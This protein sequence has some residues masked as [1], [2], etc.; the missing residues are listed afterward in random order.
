MPRFL[1]QALPLFCGAA[2]LAIADARLGRRTRAAGLAVAVAVTGL[3]AARG[4]LDI[5][6]DRPA[7]AGVAIGLVDSA[8]YRLDRLKSFAGATEWANAH[9]P[10]RARVVLFGNLRVHP[11]DRRAVWRVEWEPF[12]LLDLAAASRG[13]RDLDRKV[14]QLGITHLLYDRITAVNRGAQ[15]DFL[16]PADRT[17][18]VWAAWWR[19]RAV[20]VHES[21]AI[22]LWHGAFFIYALG[23]S[24]RAPD[25]AG[26]TLV[27]PG[28]EGWLFRAEKLRRAGRGSAARAVFDRI[29]AAAGDFGIVQQAKVAIFE[30]DLARDEARRILESVEARG[31][32]SVWLLTTLARWADEAGDHAKARAWRG[33][34][35]AL[36]WKLLTP[37]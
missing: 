19:N 14:R 4:W 2:E 34:A 31:L 12:Q 23:T 7:R 32:R 37:R 22:D 36:T 18:P 6:T 35:E 11:L 20:L 10:A 29:G 28:I 17:L 1:V 9:L 27:L 24:P 5:W 15:L 30:A 25:G 33:K 16:T 26:A 8:A 13:P 21:P 3:E